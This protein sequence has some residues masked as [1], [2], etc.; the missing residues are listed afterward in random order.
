MALI[1]YREALNLAMSEE[2]DDRV[3]LMGEEVVPVHL[4]PGLT[5][6]ALNQGP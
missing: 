1:Q 4:S 5:S 2:M 6:R 3:F